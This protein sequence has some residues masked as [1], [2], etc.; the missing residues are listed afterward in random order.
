MGYN[1]WGQ[2]LSSFFSCWR[3][4]KY[5]QIV[6]ILWAGASQSEKT[7]V[8]FRITLQ[9]NVGQSSPRFMLKCKH[10]ED[11]KEREQKSGVVSDAPQ[12]SKILLMVQCRIL[13]QCSVTASRLNQHRSILTTCDGCNLCRHKHYKFKLYFTKQ[14][15]KEMLSWQDVRQVIHEY[16]HINY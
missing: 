5:I 11:P 13:H 6:P 12:C 10:E 2:R 4:N 9:A 3:Q 1:E 7:P 15:L 8:V 16:L 14:D